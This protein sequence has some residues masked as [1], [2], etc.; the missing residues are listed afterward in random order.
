MPSVEGICC[1]AVQSEHGE[2]VEGSVTVPLNSAKSYTF[3]VVPLETGDFQIAVYMFSRPQDD[4]VRKTLQVVVSRGV[5]TF[6]L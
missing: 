6:S 4:L 1:N 5:K 3:I 2:S